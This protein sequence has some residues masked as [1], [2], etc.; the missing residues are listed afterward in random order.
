MAKR[1]G[2]EGSARM[3]AQP[4]STQPGGASVS[5]IAYITLWLGGEAHHI[6]AWQLP[7]GKHPSLPAL[8][9]GQPLAVALPG[10]PKSL[11]VALDA[12]RATGT[13]AQVPLT[14]PLG[15]LLC[16]C[17]P[18]LP[19]PP[20]DPISCTIPLAFFA[21]AEVS[22]D[23]QPAPKDAY[24]SAADALA[25]FPLLV[26]QVDRTGKIVALNARSRDLLKLT[27]GQVLPLTAQQTHPAWQK[28]DNHEPYRWCDLPVARVLQDYQPIE[29]FMMFGIP[30]TEERIP[31]LAKAQPIYSATGEVTGA[32]WLLLPITTK[33]FADGVTQRRA[34]EIMAVIESMRDGIM[35][36]D[37]QGELWQMN[38]A[39]RQMLG[40]D[41]LM[42]DPIETSMEMRMRAYAPQHHDGEP[43]ATA[44]WPMSRA[45]QGENTEVVELSLMRMDGVR[46]STVISA[47]PLHDETGRLTGAVAIIRDMT[48]HRRYE[49]MREGFMSLASHELRTPLTSLVLA[50]HIMH[51]QLVRSQAPESLLDLN[52]DLLS[53]LRQLN[54]LVDNL[55][56]MTG[57]TG[58]QFELRRRWT[59]VS[60]IV[61]DV[62]DELRLL[63]RRTPRTFILKYLDEPISLNIDPQRFSQVI[64]NLVTNAIKFSSADSPIEIEAHY[65]TQDDVPWL[66]IDIID[67]GVGIPEEQIHTLFNRVIE[68]EEISRSSGMGY[69]LYLSRAIMRKHG[70]DIAANSVLH[71]GSTFSVRFPLTPP[72]IPAPEEDAEA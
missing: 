15:P 17:T 40:W 27:L 59:D 35:L 26:V 69:S 34:S 32:A 8:T 12:V 14:T 36:Y 24:A 62:I 47:S 64:Y 41:R 29:E 55:L 33:V 10:V 60:K 67:A 4:A 70:G 46:I 56:D 51:K 21:K 48:L 65:F 42:V 68:S 7:D 30:Q 20:F 31:F 6:Q 58:G 49:Q 3:P 52:S 25:A 44:D 5:A 43:L 57:L 16:F 54:R 1:S 72:T 9:V 22:A 18:A 37:A 38:P 28:W 23:G 39:A 11:I 63:Q 2:G 45:L 50:Q 13:A 71:F 19:Q 53:Q 61:H 66:S